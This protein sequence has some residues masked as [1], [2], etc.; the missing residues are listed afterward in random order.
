MSLT[1]WNMIVLSLKIIYIT[2]SIGLFLIGLNSILT[3][4]LYL[5]NRAKVWGVPAQPAPSQWPAVTIQLPIYNERYVLDRLIRSVTGLDYPADCLQ[6]QVLDDSTDSSSE[7]ALCLVNQYHALGFNIQYIH[8]TSRAGYKAG[9][10]SEGLRT[11]TGELIAV[12][13]ADFTPASNWLKQVIPCFQEARVGFVQTRWAYLNRPNNLVTRMASLVMD[14]HFVVEQTARVG[15]GL[16][17]NFNGSGGIWRR[18]AIE[19]AGGWQTDT[20]TEDLDLS[21]RAQAAGWKAAYLPEV[22]VPSESPAQIDAYKKQQFRWVKGTI[23][24]VRKDL[25]PLW[26]SGLAFLPRLMMAVNLVLLGWSFLLVL[27]AQLLFLPIGLVAPGIIPVLSFSGVV[28]IG[29]AMLFLFA[30]TEELPRLRD[31]L[32]LLPALMML[33][34]GVSVNNTIGALSGLVSMGGVFERT[35]KFDLASQNGKWADNH[36][37]VRISPVV[38]GELAMALYFGVALFVL[39]PRLGLGIVPYI[40]VSAG[41]YL[42]VALMSLGQ[43][44]QRMQG[45]LVKKRTEHSTGTVC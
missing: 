33:G 20:L 40:L 7:Q 16:L 10:L 19:S 28:A 32:V 13:D 1:Y 24:V 8:R 35:P 42:M 45:T 39:V 3:S 27:L 30:R 12:F 23:Q 38:C 4:I 15:S 36:Y 26:G 43:N 18:A 9:A 17:T 29:P 41:S 11:A 2:C 14:A 22:S 37:A 5:K 6:I 21:L 44:V 25:K 31:R 34:M